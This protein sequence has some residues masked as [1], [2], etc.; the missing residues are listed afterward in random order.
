[1]YTYSKDEQETI[2]SFNELEAEASI[3]TFNRRLINLLARLAGERPE[4]C[5]LYR[6]L[7]SSCEYMVPKSWIRVKPPREASEAQKEAARAALQ[8]MRASAPAQSE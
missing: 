2:I 6:K 1:M 8:R 3:Y 4:E 5:R 7:D